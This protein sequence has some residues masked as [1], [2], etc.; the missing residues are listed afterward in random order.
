MFKAEKR[1]NFKTIQSW[2]NIQKYEEKI[3]NEKL[4]QETKNHNN[5]E[6]EKPKKTRP[7]Y[8]SKNK[9]RKLG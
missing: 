6:P 2:K 5:P 3:T 7:E 1:S 9:N 4:Q 8:C